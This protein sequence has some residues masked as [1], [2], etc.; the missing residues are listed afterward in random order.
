MTNARMPTITHVFAGVATHDTIALVERFPGADERVLATDV[1]HAGGG[2]AATAAVAASRLG[3]SVAFVGS[4][5]DDAEADAILDDL[6]T[7]GVDISGV[8]RVADR[9]SGSS[10]VIVDSSQATRAIINRPPPPITLDPRARELLATA[11]WVHVDQVG[12]SVVSEWWRSAMPRPSLSVDAG[13]PIDGFS[14]DGVELYVPTISAL[15][16]RYGDGTPEQLLRDAIAEGA[17]TVVATSG[18]AGSFALAADGRFVHVPGER[19]AL[20][21]TL[22]AGD[23]FH[24]ALLAALYH[25]FDLDHGLRYANRVAF[26]S[27]QGLDGRS[28]IPTHDDV[29]GALELG[30]LQVVRPTPSVTEETEP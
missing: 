11:E 14:A 18:S 23:V 4:V 12:W 9:R 26:R 22:G 20:L 25:G 6:M 15:R 1:V 24:G 8:S 30:E 21:S 2:P 13:N 29:V 5:G 28:A 16:L 3:V 17:R 19:G 27:C 7:E 10:V